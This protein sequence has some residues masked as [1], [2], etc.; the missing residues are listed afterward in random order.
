MYLMGVQSPVST[1][2]Y[3]R[4]E[5]YDKAVP[6]YDEAHDHKGDTVLTVMMGIYGTVE[7]AALW[8]GESTNTMT[9]L[10]FIVSENDPS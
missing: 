7:G 4:Y 2:E 3:A 6:H 5:Y 9:N 1:H 8:C 10:G